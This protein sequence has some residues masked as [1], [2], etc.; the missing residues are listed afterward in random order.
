MFQV[1][2]LSSYIYILVTFCFC[3]PGLGIT[4]EVSF[5]KGVTQGV[6]LGSIPVVHNWVPRDCTV[7]CE[8]GCSFVFRPE[9]SVINSYKWIEFR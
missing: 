4:G 1:S 6:Q 8:V 2:E 7:S 5:D 3:S 9:G